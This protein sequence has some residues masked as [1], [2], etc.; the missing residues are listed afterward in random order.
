MILRPYQE[1]LKNNIR[2]LFSSGHT[3]VILCSP[4]GSGKTVTFAD[5]ARDS[6]RNG[7]RVMVAVD[8]KELL[9]QSK[10]KLIAYGLD[11]SIITSGRTVRHGQKCYVATVQTLIRRVFPDIDL[12]II[13]EAHKQIFDKLLEPGRYDNVF[14]IAATATPKRSGKMTQLSKYYSKIVEAVS[15]QDL[16]IEGYLTPAITYGAK[17]DTSKIK[18]KGA[19]FENSEL[20][21]AFDKRVLYAGVVDK[22][23]KFAPD[24]QA[25]CFCINV[26]HSK[27][28]CHA[29]NARGIS[30]VHLDGTTPKTQREGI[31]EDFHNK[32]YKVLVNVEVLTTGYDEWKIETVIVNLATKSLPK[33]LQMPGRGSRIVP[34]GVDYVKDHFS[35]I[36][37]GGNTYEH[38]FWEQSREWSLSHKTKDEV[39]VAP[40]KECPED[41]LDENG[42]PGCGC[43]VPAQAP[44]CK[45]CGYIFPPPK[46]EEPQEAEFIQLENY[47]LLRPELVG[48]QF[49][50][51]TIPELEEVKMVKGFQQG[52]L[53]KQILI[54]KDLD[55]LEYAKY[56]KYKWPQMWV[57]RMENMYIRK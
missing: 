25:I 11:P 6:V 17:M 45:Y 54:H 21:K 50:S 47:E 23:E 24:T 57:D 4:T 34:D 55:L 27:K 33:W 51:M 40:V 5:M 32:R 3:R 31:L 46:K 43:I 41:L 10:K 16:I 2:D 35:I 36:D 22:Y 9:E 26:E 18:M 28:V 14:V 44:L 39:G 19:D 42:R 30:A 8:R 20:Y 1:K 53:I 48:K 37:M 15:V 52:W 7:F 29:F 13:D 56:K 49:G 12:L 38:G